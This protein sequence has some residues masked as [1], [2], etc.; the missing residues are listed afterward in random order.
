MNIYIHAHWSTDC[1]IGIVTMYYKV[2]TILWCDAIWTVQ[3][4]Q[5]IDLSPAERE[6]EREREIPYIVMD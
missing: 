4:D 3:Y 6:R 2:T 1:G 5:L